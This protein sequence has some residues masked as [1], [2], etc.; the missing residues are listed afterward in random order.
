MRGHGF[1]RSMERNYLQLPRG[2]PTRSV[3]ARNRSNIR[4][5]LP[6]IRPV[7]VHNSSAICPSS[8]Q[9]P[10]SKRSPCRIIR[11]RAVMSG[12]DCENVVSIGQYRPQAKAGQEA[13]SA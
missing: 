6:K 2:N 9:V 5:I 7:R 12:A 8:P 10:I 4:S 1:D 3:A 11:S 13:K